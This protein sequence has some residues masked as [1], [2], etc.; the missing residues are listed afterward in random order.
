VETE[1]G[2]MT[3]DDDDTWY[4]RVSAN[5]AAAVDDYRYAGFKQEIDSRINA[6]EDRRD[7]CSYEEA[8][9]LSKSKPEEM[10]AHVKRE[11]KCRAAVA[12]CTV[13]TTI[14]AAVFLAVGCALSA[15]DTS[16]IEAFP[17]F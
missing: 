8:L 11:R 10:Y 4:S 1:D 9:L 2:E 7:R 3:L 5:L 17:T 13:R 14:V 15:F 12:L 6:L 16:E